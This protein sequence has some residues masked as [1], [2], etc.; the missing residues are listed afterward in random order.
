MAP[1][2][3]KGSI[4]KSTS[5]EDNLPAKRTPS[6]VEAAM[7]KAAQA[8]DELRKV[9]EKNFDHVGERFP[10]EARRIHYGETKKRGIYGEATAEEACALVEEGIDVGVLPKGRRSDA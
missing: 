5:D 3:G 1:M 8:F 7:E 10:E 9:V 6:D 4:G 2:I